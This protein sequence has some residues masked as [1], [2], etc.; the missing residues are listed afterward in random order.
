M[1]SGSF[2]KTCYRTNDLVAKEAVMLSIT[3]ESPDNS[4]SLEETST[5]AFT[6][7]LVHKTLISACLSL[8]LLDKQEL[9]PEIPPQL[10]FRGRHT[11]TEGLPLQ[12]AAL[13]VFVW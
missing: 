6:F 10:Y 4:E 7:P 13:I 8:F 11:E 12:V 2:E 5:G 9:P 1:P 3:I